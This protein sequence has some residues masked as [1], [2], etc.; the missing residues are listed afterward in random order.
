MVCERC[1]GFKIAEYFY[2][3]DAST[4]FWSYQGYRCVNC[5]SITVESENL[6]VETMVAVSTGVASVDTLRANAG[7]PFFESA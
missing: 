7:T 5:G 2:G 3:S 4:G 1:D 6:G